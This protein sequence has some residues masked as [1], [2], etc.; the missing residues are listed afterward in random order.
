MAQEPL[1]KAADEV[2]LAK[3]IELGCEAQRQLQLAD[4]YLSGHYTTKRSIHW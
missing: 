4:Q 1:L 3:R 2:D